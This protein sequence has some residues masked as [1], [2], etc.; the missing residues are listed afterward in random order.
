MGSAGVGC[1][2]LG[3]GLLR[4]QRR[5]PGVGLRGGYGRLTRRLGGLPMGDRR[6]GQEAQAHQQR[7]GQP[8]LRRS[9]EQLGLWRQERDAEVQIRFINPITG[10]AVQIRARAFDGPVSV[11]TPTIDEVPVVEH[12]IVSLQRKA[13]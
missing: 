4:L 8:H 7:V 2:G 11:P 10:P 6:A 1:A 3:G 12:L 9:V 5:G 13:A